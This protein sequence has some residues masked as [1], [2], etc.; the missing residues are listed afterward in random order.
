MISST[1]APGLGPL[2]PAPAR[3]GGG[4]AGAIVIASRP[5][6]AA[7]AAVMNAANRA[8][9]VSSQSRARRRMASNA[10]KAAGRMS[11]TLAA[12][13][14]RVMMPPMSRTRSTSLLALTVGFGPSRVVARACGQRLVMLPG[15]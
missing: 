14:S 9:T 2:T 3:P 15:R 7:S 11:G 10:S 8:G 1:A 13:R 4:S 5:S 12:F 6:T